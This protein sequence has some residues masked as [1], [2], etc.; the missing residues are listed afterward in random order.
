MILNHLTKSEV[1]QCAISEMKYLEEKGFDPDAITSLQQSKLTKLIQRASNTQYYKGLKEE[2][3]FYRLEKTPKVVVKENPDLFHSG[4]KEKAIKYYETSGT[5]GIPTPTPRSA[6]D[7]IWNTISVASLWKRVIQS[8][9]RVVSMLP[10]DLSPIGDHIANVCEYLDTTFV[11]SYPFALG[12]CDWDRVQQLFIRY[13]PTCLFASPGVL[14]QLMRL[15]KRRNT[16]ENLRESIHKIMLLGEVSTPGMRA[17]LE[18][19]WRAEVFDASY[20]STETGT[21]A[22]TCEHGRL[23]ALL[24]SFILELYEKDKVIQFQPGMTGELVVTPLNNYAK[25][26]LRYAIGDLVEVSQEACTCGMGL[27]VLKILGRQEEMIQVNG[28]NL[29]LD[30]IEQVIYNARGIT[31]YMVETNMDNSFF[32]LLLEKDVDYDGK[33]GDI[34]LLEK[35][36]EQIG[37]KWD[38]VILLNQLPSVTKSGAGQ[39]NWKKTN[40]RLVEM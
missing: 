24:H 8:D 36:F 31:G 16:F 35:N 22:A 15:L 13:R 33:E 25:P 9:D 20:G 6:R 11:R 19:Q 12:I 34:D 27:P 39:K 18:K 37:I 21:I 29:R 1:F 4:M 7:I 32:R 40:I 30:L 23:H 26:V 5:T 3:D 14:I 17:M 10:S 38:G 2:R 28:V